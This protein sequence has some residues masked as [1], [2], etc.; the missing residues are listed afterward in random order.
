MIAR[1]NGSVCK[2]SGHP[3]ALGYIC[4]SA[5]KTY[6][7]HV[8]KRLRRPFTN[9]ACGERGRRVTGDGCGVRKVCAVAN[10]V[11]AAAAAAQYGISWPTQGTS[12]A[13][14]AT[15]SGI[16]GRAQPRSASDDPG[17]TAARRWQRVADTLTGLC[18]DI[19]IG[20]TPRCNTI[21]SKI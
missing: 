21:G 10:V 12:S 18:K 8:D 13:I 11:D 16:A 1:A 20:T 3:T 6:L 15:G 2:Q 7:G 19:L 9:K 14:N 17:G 5:W 4:R